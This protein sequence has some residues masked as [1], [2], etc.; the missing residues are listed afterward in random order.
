MTKKIHKR[1]VTGFIRKVYYA[2][3][4]VKLGDQDKSWAPHKVCFVCVEDLKKWSKG[5]KESIQIWCP[6]DMEGAEKSQ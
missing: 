1:N 3:F 2:Y 6:D 5:K 4:C